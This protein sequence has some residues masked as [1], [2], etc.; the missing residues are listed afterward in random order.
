MSN[1]FTK[2]LENKQ[3]AAYAFMRILTGFMFSFHGIQKIFG[4]LADH[5]APAFGTQMWVGGV[6]ELVCGVLIALGAFT[7]YAAFL[8][9]GTMAVAYAQF[10]WNFA[11]DSNFFPALNG[12]ELAAVYALLWFFVACKGGGMFSVD[13][14]LAKKK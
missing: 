11:V 3:E 12:G 6:I 4:V 9:S 2:F 14:M 13:A 7:P 1:P 5:P 8:A 10:H